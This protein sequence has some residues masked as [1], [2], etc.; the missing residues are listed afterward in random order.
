ML[1]IENSKGAGKK[2]KSHHHSSN[3][4]HKKRKSHPKTVGLR[5]LGNTCFMNAVLQSLKY[6]YGHDYC[7]A[8]IN[9]RNTQYFVMHPIRLLSILD[10][11]L[12]A[13][14]QSSPNTYKSY[15]H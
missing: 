14:Y 8:L 6:G 2:R 1:D 3:S 10:C 13:I 9:F 12:P 5:N 15:H 11:C 7:C 4:N